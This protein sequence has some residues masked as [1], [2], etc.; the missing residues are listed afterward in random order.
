MT[1]GV[2]PDHEQALGLEARVL[3]PSGPH[4]YGRGRGWNGAPSRPEPGGASSGL[5]WLDGPA[6]WASVRRGDQ[7]AP[8]EGPAAD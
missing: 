4:T 6:T 2:P 1:Q 5:G 8:P 7:T 3:P